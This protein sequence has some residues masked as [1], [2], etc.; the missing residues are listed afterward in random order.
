MKTKFFLKDNPVEKIIAGQKYTTPQ[1]GAD[2]GFRFGAL[3][4]VHG[5][6]T[7]HHY[8]ECQSDRGVGKQV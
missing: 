8:E 3:I 4:A 6:S 2:N 5:R 1:D 7:S